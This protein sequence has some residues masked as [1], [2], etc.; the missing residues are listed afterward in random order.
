M[1]T[2]GTPDIIVDGETGL[3][4][5]TPGKLADDVRRLRADAELRDRL[6]RGAMR[7]AESRF[8]TFS[9]AGRIEQ[10]YAELIAG[11]AR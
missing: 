1:N 9:V 11:R 10:L 3:L 2:G 8:D 6:G 5:S 4:S 7:H